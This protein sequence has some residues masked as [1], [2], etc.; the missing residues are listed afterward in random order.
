MTAWLS[1]SDHILYAKRVIDI[2]IIAYSYCY[3]D[4]SF[5]MIGEIPRSKMF[6]GLRT[7]KKL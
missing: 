5:N 1:A 7:I 4:L 6:M 3:R 2:L